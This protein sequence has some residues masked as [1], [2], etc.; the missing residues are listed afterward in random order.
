MMPHTTVAPQAY[1]PG[2]PPV[3]LSIA[4]SDSSAGAGIQADLKTFTAHG[5]YG[6]TAVTSVVAEAPG[7]VTYVELL[8]AAAIA[9]QIRV[10]DESF[11]IAAV[12]TGML[13]GRA[14]M[15]AILENWAPLAQRGIPLVVDPVMIS[16]SGRRLL[17]E[18]AMELLVTE[19][20]QRARLITPNLN[21]AGV[22]LGV[23]PT[24]R[25]EMLD[26]ARRLMDRWGCAVLLKGGHL[27]GDL[28]PDVLVDGAAEAW[29]EA[30]RITVVKTHGTGCTY[31]AAITA[32]LA[33]GLT[34][35]AA[36]RSA[37]AFITEAIAQFYRWQGGE[38]E[39][40]ALNHTTGKNWPVS[41]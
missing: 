4:G 20:L 9:A 39:I 33:H 24:T 31:S 22:L 1:S 17:E 19:F 8:P 15:E 28:C 14:Q 38:G 11:P 35:E 16:T 34:L 41:G 10:L 40:D 18:D 37:K 2:H 26:G 36:V 5:C 7:R 29:V 23:R 21:E 32:G 6:L 12:K 3:V 13:G 25:L 30:P 27:S